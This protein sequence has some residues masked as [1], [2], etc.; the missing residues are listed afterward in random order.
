[1][2]P[3]ERAE[4]SETGARDDW[5]AP[6]RLSGAC[7]SWHRSSHRGAAQVAGAAPTEKQAEKLRTKLLAEA[8]ASRSARTNASLGYLLDRWLPQHDIDE[9][10]RESYDSLIR[11]HIRPALGDTPPTLLVRKATETV[12]QFYGEL[13]RC[14]DRCDGRMLIDHKIANPH[15]CVEAGCRPRHPQDDARDGRDRGLRHL[16][17]VRSDIKS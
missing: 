7:L 11:I 4:T 6:R 2:N 15:D 3:C 17:A 8:D 14:R 12:E 9:N 1:M 10:T 5:Q 13:R 16:H